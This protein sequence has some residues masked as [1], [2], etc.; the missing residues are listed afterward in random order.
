MTA[1]I[2]F[3]AVITCI[4]LLIFFEPLTPQKI[5][6][7]NL[8]SVVE[9]KASSEGVGESFGSAVFVNEYG[10]LV[11][12]AHVVTYSTAG[13]KRC[14]E[15]YEIRFATENIYRE[16]E[17]IRFDEELDLALLKVKD[18]CKFKYVEMGDSDKLKAGDT[19]YAIGNALNYGISIT[20]GIISIPLLN[21]EYE[22]N[23]R[24][25]IQCD[26]TI[27]EGN[28][29]GAMFDDKGRLVGITT[30]RTQNNYGET[31]Y[32][33]AYCIPINSVKEFLNN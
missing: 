12:N 18:D 6:S 23:L 14:F 31:V 32:G 29:G 5:Y 25:A 27:N 13:G 8:N 20:Q 10:M 21:I 16:I 33:I 26:L 15:K 19:V 11:T 2:C 7:N 3:A 17:L 22:N 9:L 4:I 28:S 30:F 1:A 24:K